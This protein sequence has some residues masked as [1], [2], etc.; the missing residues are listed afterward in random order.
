MS[1]VIFT[2]KLPNDPKYLQFIIDNYNKT[3]GSKLIYMPEYFE[4][5]LSKEMTSFYE[6]IFIENVF[7]GEV[8]A[9]I[10]VTKDILVS[11]PKNK[12]FNYFYL[13]FACVRKDYRNK[14]IFN[15]LLQDVLVRF[16]TEYNMIYGITFEEKVKHNINVVQSFELLNIEIN[17]QIE[18]KE[19][20][21][22]EINY[23]DLTVFYERKK[24]NLIGGVI[25]RNFPSSSEIYRYFQFNDDYL[26]LYKIKYLLNKEL[27]DMYYL[28]DTTIKLSEDLVN[29]LIKTLS[30][31]TKNGILNIPEYFINT[32]KL[33]C[34]NKQNVKI[35]NYIPKDSIIKTFDLDNVKIF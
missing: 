11:R 22:N 24:S 35:C 9:S 31:E 7:T 23:L 21:L 14:N 1:F 19:I 8:L 27:L 4:V 17:P 6:L 33:T 32:N 34:F 26:V 13:N 10:I 5:Y 25:T 18:S 16:Q 29:T 28:T 12:C 2:N 20:V 15:L 30:N 3:N